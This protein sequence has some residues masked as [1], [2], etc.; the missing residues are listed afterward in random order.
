MVNK[1][2]EIIRRYQLS[3]S[4]FADQL[5]VPRS[6]I[7]HILSERNKPSLE[8]LQKVLERYPEINTD[9]LIKGEGNIF[10]EKEDLFSQTEPVT[11][12]GE[13]QEQTKKP[14]K[15]PPQTVNELFPPENSIKS[16][17][18]HSDTIHQEYEKEKPSKELDKITENQYNRKDNKEQK[19][20]ASSKRMVKLVAFYEDNSFEEF[21]PVKKD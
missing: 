6:T 4:R 11:L 7:S 17:E 16:H 14:E 2:Q 19:Q 9:W 20:H 10:G 5:E 18:S 12:K 1:I 8:F 13:K 3:P 15:K 21:F